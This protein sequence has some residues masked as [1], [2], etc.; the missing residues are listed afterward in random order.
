MDIEDGKLDCGSPDASGHRQSVS[1]NGD[2]THGGD[3]QCDT[4]VIV[5]IKSGMLSGVIE[6][7]PDGAN[8]YVFK[9]I[10]YAQAPVGELRF[11]VIR[12]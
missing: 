6:R 4:R 3:G 9:G 5:Q 7:L 1:S 12:G 2:A 10:P 11:K 8:M